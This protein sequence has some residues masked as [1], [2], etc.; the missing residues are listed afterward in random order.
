M[1]SKRKSKNET[2]IKNP[3]VLDTI[4]KYLNVREEEK[5]LFG[6][7][8]TPIELICEMLSKLPPKVWKN[9]DLKWL[10]PANGIGN[11][12]IVVYYKLME[13]LKG[14]KP[15]KGKTLSTYIIEDMLYMVELNPINVRICKKIFKWINPK[16]K[17][18]I[19]KV[20]FF[21][22]IDPNAKPNIYPGDIKF[23]I[24]MGN[25]PY[26]SGGV[27]KGGG[28]FWKDF[29]FSSI[30]I[31]NKN[32]YL[33]FV[34]PTGW[35]KPTGKRASAGD[36]LDFFKTKHLLYLKISDEK[37][38]GF[39]RV[40]FYVFQNKSS[41]KKLTKIENIHNGK[42]CISAIDISNIPFIPHLINNMV[43]N[44]LS[45]LFKNNKNDKFEIIRCQYFQPKKH[46]SIKSGIPHT[47][48]Y[49]VIEKK[50]VL[51]N[52]KIKIDNKEYIKNPKIILTYK[53][54]KKKAYLYPKFY[55]DLIGSS[56]NTMY[57]IIEKKDDWKSMIVLFKSE[58]IHFLLLITQYSESPNHINEFKILNL[59]SKPDKK[60]KT[61]EDVF[62]YFK[63]T[64][65]E[66]AHIL[67]IIK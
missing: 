55:R 8:F 6:E 50:Y 19:F 11:F 32:G 18:N 14:Y 24:I 60:L 1:S 40:D 45:K 3:T 42:K 25:P 26:N 9:P 58:L 61:N 30:D 31:L 27:Q 28:V 57:Q 17:P 29:V 53:S 59:I 22:W 52:T 23:D 4:K 49:D 63:L 20:S 51:R 34:H 10:D 16:A 43:V 13:S 48:F 47:F 35:R 5:N 67:D 37:I 65:N 2:L 44:I 21:K 54:G 64:K 39:P 15:P 7:V 12:P 38:P 56:S 46:V 36:I 62:K 41:G 66:I 33:V